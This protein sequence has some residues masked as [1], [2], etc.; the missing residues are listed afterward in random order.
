[1]T[2]KPFKRGPGCEPLTSTGSVSAGLVGGAV[3][4]QLGGFTPLKRSRIDLPASP[5]FTRQK[6]LPYRASGPV[7]LAIKLII[8]F[9]YQNLKVLEEHPDSFLLLS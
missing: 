7:S 3:R 5:P 2:L 9:P 8:I 4:L 1:M 6:P